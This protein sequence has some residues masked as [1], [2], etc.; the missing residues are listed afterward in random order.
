MR[1]ARLALA[2]AAV[3]LVA[4]E[5]TRAQGA[6]AIEVPAGVEQKTLVFSRFRTQLAEGDV[7]GDIRTGDSCSGA[8]RLRMNARTEQAVM[9][10]AVRAVREE[11]SRAGYK[12]AG[13]SQ[14]SLFQEDERRTPDLLLGGMLEEFHASYCS[15]AAGSRTDGK[16]RVRV[17]W[18]VYDTAER[19][20]VHGATKVGSY[21]TKGAEALREGDFFAMAY[22]DAIRQLLAERKFYDAVVTL[23]APRAAAQPESAAHDKVMLPRVAPLADALAAN[24]TFTRAAVVTIT[25][26]GGAGSGF[27]VSESG[28]VLTNSHVVGEQ[29]FVRVILATG[30]ELVG[31]VV[32]RDPGR[33]VALVKTEGTSFIALAL[34]GEEAN[35]GAEVFAIGSPLGEALSGTVTRGI[36]SGY[37]T[38]RGRRYIQSDVELLPGNSGGPLLD[39]SGRV[40][41]L[42][43]M[44]LGGT[45][46]NFFVPIHEALASLG[47]TLA[48]K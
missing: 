20:V 40:L 43:V 17:R 13:R 38:I 1:A 15:S 27:F 36:V 42:A 2:A 32:Q 3:A 37:R 35:V 41:G 25:H 21:E 11:L 24:M 44:G 14:Q 28:H 6:A 29:R 12:D 33:D 22:R 18:E 10:P 48:G 45:R 47:I 4:A 19:R 31:E 5:G 9:S 26:A 8:T 7:I 23:S 16:V 39:R 30:R 46:I 34:A